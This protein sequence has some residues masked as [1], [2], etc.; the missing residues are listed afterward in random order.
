MLIDTLRAHG[1]NI[2][3]VSALMGKTT[4]EV[5]P[6]LTP[7]QRVRTWPDCRGL[8]HCSRSSSD[9]IVLVFFIGDVLM[10]ARL[11]LVGI[12]AIID[13]LRRPH[14]EASPGYQ[15]ACRGADSG[16]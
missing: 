9:F 5:M 6:K 10:S 14:R 15:S 4:A 2:V 8:L 1:Y 3:Q 13:R 12:L 7:W 11:V 16:L